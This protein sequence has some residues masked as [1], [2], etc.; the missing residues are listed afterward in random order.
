MTSHESCDMIHS[1][2][3]MRSRMWLIRGV[4]WVIWVDLCGMIFHLKKGWSHLHG[5]K[6]DKFDQ[7]RNLFFMTHQNLF[8]K[9]QNMFYL[10]LYFSPNLSSWAQVFEV[11]IDQKSNC[12]TFDEMS[13]RFSMRF[14]YWSISNQNNDIKESLYLWSHPG[15]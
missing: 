10:I 6:I 4:C 15:C 14:S 3:F 13:R 12:N 7:L 1:R 9:F 5:Y 8:W 2:W 11:K